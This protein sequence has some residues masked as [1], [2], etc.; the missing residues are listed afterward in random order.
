MPRLISVQF[1][2]SWR[3]TTFS[4]VPSLRE[5]MQQGRISIFG[6]HNFLRL[7]HPSP[8]FPSVALRFSQIADITKNLPEW[9]TAH[10]ETFGI[11]RNVYIR[12]LNQHKRVLLY[13]SSH[14]VTVSGSLYIPFFFFSEWSFFFRERRKAPIVPNWLMEKY[15]KYVWIPTTSE[16]FPTLSVPRTETHHV[17]DFSLAHRA[18]SV[19]LASF[20]KRKLL[21][22]DTLNRELIRLHCAR[23]RVQFDKTGSAKSGEAR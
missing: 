20:L 18:L 4:K 15:R 10:S 13:C 23:L 1:V 2:A 9:H 16:P 17:A 11:L 5:K 7:P 19:V 22:L 21:P 12:Y 6:R 8:F 14:C 3:V